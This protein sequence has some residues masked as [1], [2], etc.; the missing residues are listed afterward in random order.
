[1]EKWTWRPGSPSLENSIQIGAIKLKKYAV[2]RLNK[3]A[4]FG[5]LSDPVPNQNGVPRQTFV[6]QFTAYCGSYTRTLAIA[7][8]VVGT[9]LEDTV[10]IVVRHD[11][12]VTDQLMVRLDGV[13]YRIVSVAADDDINAFDVV[14]M[15]QPNGGI[16]DEGQAD[17]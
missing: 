15:K 8:Q 4:T 5:G 16:T 6:P 9:D 3:L 13:L 11:S 14:T 12:R 1:M 7:Y 10:A 17:E 2:S